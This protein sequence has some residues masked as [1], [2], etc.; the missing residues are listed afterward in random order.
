MS[1]PANL[2]VWLINL[3]RADRRRE[4][5]IQRLEALGLSFEIFD[6]VDGRAEAEALAH[7]VDRAAFERNTGS[8][9]LPGK[10]GV[11]HSHLRV[12]QTFAACAEPAALILED[13]V[14]FHDGFLDAV[15]AAL[16]VI[17]HWDIVR[18]NAIRA[19]IPICQGVVGPYR[20]NAYLGPFTG[21][22][23]YLIRREIAA[24][25]AATLLPMTRP[26]DHELN[27][28]F[29]HGHRLR[30]L[31]PWPSHVDD[32]GESQITGTAFANVRKFPLAQRMP[33]YRLKAGNCLRRAAGLAR[34]GA[35][36]PSARSLGATP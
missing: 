22:G 10:I 20:L 15:T 19:K 4:A 9:L 6:A 23:C 7:S 14:V 5:M 1:L 32:E 29:V 27:R 12:W 24:Q 21:N 13:D 33:Y 35:L 28:F 25:L 17:D 16:S 8:A 34:E 11:Y 18:F 31:E 2:P 30:G 26:L 3:R 36:R